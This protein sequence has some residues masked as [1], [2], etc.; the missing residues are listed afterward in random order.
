[1]DITQKSTHTFFI[2]SILTGW[3]LCCLVYA[4][5]FFSF[6][7]GNHD[8]EYLRH[9]TELHS[10]FFEARYSQH[11]LSVLLFNGQFL[12][13][14]TML[15]ALLGVAVFAFCIGVYLNIPYN[16]FA[17][18]GLMLFMGLNPHIFVLLYYQHI[19]I[20]FIYW[21]LICVL[22]LYWVEQKPSIC[23][24]LILT[25]ALIGGLGS[26][27]PFFALIFGLF[28]IRR[29]FDYVYNQRSL[30]EIIKIC[31]MFVL[32][33]GLALGVQKVI[34]LWLIKIG[35]VSPQMYNL[36]IRSATDIIKI[37]PQEIVM[38]FE[39]LFHQ[40]AFIGDGYIAMTVLMVLAGLS[41]IL[42]K[43]KNKWLTA[44]FILVCF[45]ASRFTFIVADQ[46]SGALFRIEYWGRLG[47]YILALSIL[48]K[49]DNKLI[50]N[51]VYVLL[52]CCLSIFAKANLEIQKVQA[53]AFNAEADF[54]Q[55]IF[56]RVVQHKD[57]D[58]HKPYISFAFGLPNLR[59]H[60]YNE[61]NIQSDEI[62]DYS[63]IFGFD[64]LNKLFENE[65]KSPIAV[66]MEIWEGNFFRATRN[67]LPGNLY[68][69][70]DDV[71]IQPI[72]YWLYNK[73][74]PYPDEQ[75]V[76][77][78][79]RYIILIPDAKTFYQKREQFIQGIKDKG[80]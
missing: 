78:D 10:G 30:W 69:S 79:D 21:P 76:Y 47:L 44:C 17:Y 6:F 3:G 53:L 65:G 58:I 62:L 68:N 32:A 19:L 8:W 54:Q 40:Y 16:M 55:R 46:T 52:I 5:M 48:F 67:E 1:M 61:T 36:Q 70:R 13:V 66:G 51:F 31:M 41:I 23:R 20:S 28:A 4:F 45:F 25:I 64:F 27:P 74:K 77:I 2:K 43:A 29:L 71:Y 26:Y 72:S 7:W 11:I 14:I 42:L 60:F 50:K 9:G 80:Y 24:F 35:Y 37:L 63:M 56:E 49:Q 12:P 22:A 38:S 34:H 15:F 73:A 75:A 57:F 39:Q 33:L 18:V 59:R